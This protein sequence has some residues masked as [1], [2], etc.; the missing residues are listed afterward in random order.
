MYHGLL[1]DRNAISAR[2]AKTI[3]PLEIPL[4]VSLF[5]TLLMKKSALKALQIVS[6]IAGLALF[7]YMIKQA[8]LET[9]ARY[10]R[11]MGWGFALI[12][13]LSALRNC[14]RT[15]SWYLAIAPSE[16]NVGYWS[17][18]NVMLAGEAIKYLT[19]TGPLLGEPAKAAMVRRKVPLLE[20]FSSIVVE[21]LIYNLT[22]FLVMLAGLPALAWLIEVPH[23]IKLAAYVFALV[24][25]L[26]V[27]LMWLAVRGRWF[28]LA[29]MLE[30]LARLTSRR[31]R[32][33]PARFEKTVGRVRRVEENIYSFYET[34]R[35][36]FF[37][38]FAVNMLAHFINVIEVY[39]IL[40]LMG[41]SA[42]VA[43]GFVVEAVTKVINGAF[44][45]VPARAGVYESGN[46]LALDALGLGASAGVALAIIR[47]LRAFV[48]IGYGLVA[49]AAITLK[50]KRAD[51]SQATKT[52]RLTFDLSEQN[53]KT[54]I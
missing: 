1:E 35:G 53:S 38:I 52:D 49:I 40:A 26:T 37:L 2:R 48:W 4:A 3:G 22:V 30:Q 6:L 54:K 45:F 29:R 32:E 12:L 13:A 25:I 20:G 43:G 47:K 44:F 41:L 11:M 28:I 7:V 15:A 36:A 17:L 24:I 23:N 27:A 8:G 34:R 39:I 16:R 33:E 18:A 21:N 14:A 46:A 19:A 42:T 51:Q 10:L 31:S 50:D 5:F 9:L